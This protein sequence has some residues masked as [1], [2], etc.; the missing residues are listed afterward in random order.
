MLARK[1]AIILAFKLYNLTSSVCIAHELVPGMSD[2]VRMVVGVIH[3]Y[4]FIDM[5][6]WHHERFRGMRAAQEACYE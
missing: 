4:P 1:T 3:F 6:G 5:I 2:L